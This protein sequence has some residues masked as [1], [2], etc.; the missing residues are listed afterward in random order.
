MDSS[1]PYSE[2]SSI[3]LFL[4]GSE[5]H[6]VNGHVEVT[7]PDN[8]RKGNKP[9]DNGISDAHMGT[10]SRDYSCKTCYQDKELCPGHFGYYKLNYPVQS[11]LFMKDIMRWL[12]IICYNCGK[13]IVKYI[14]MRYRPDKI[15]NQFV[16]MARPSGKILQC[17]HCESVQPNIV[18]DRDDNFT[19]FREWYD[20]TATNTSNKSKMMRK[21]KLMA[22][23]IARIF[24]KVSDE[25]VLDMGKPLYCHPRK[26][27]LDYIPVPPNTIR[28]NM[29]E[30]GGGRSGNDDLTV[31]L[32]HIVEANRRLPTIIPNEISDEMMM[33]INNISLE[34]Y[35]LVKGSSAQSNK[36]KITTTGGNKQLTSVA[37]RL[38]R[39]YGRIRRN[40]MGRRVNYMARSF[41]TCDPSL[42]LDEVGVPRSIAQG[43]QKP[44]VV[45]RYNYEECM[46]YVMNAAKGAYPKA[47]RVCRKATGAIHLLGPNRE[48]KPIEIGDIIYRDIIDGDV[49][50]FNRQPSLESSSISSHKVVIMEEGNTIRMNVLSCVLYN[51]DGWYNQVRNSRGLYKLSSYL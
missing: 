49:V 10:T 2:L 27:I 32:R 13:L 41:I 34:V 9:V 28:P 12:K 26:L 11:P 22:H 3:G 5:D 50:N 46:F 14:K 17:A 6:K 29:N 21:E 4:L 38:P 23:E 7:E 24:N 37:K 47:S 1:I 31:L 20:I 35:E 18:K 48:N 19:I 40:L 44:M 36:R 33:N 16:K 15:L 45:R 43:I 30:K 51:A 39:K 42:R 25:T 8:L